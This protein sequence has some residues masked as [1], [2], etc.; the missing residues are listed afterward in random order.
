MGFNYD[1]EICVELA[2]Y[3]L[4]NGYVRYTRTNL[5]MMMDMFLLWDPITLLFVVVWLWKKRGFILY[6]LDILLGCTIFYT[7]TVQ[8]W[9]IGIISQILTVWIFIVMICLVTLRRYSF[10]RCVWLCSWG[11]ICISGILCVFMFQRRWC[12]FSSGG[13]ILIL[14]IRKF[15]FVEGNGGVRNIIRWSISTRTMAARGISW[16]GFQ[17]MEGALRLIRSPVYN[18]NFCRTIRPAKLLMVLVYLIG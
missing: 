17:W 6:K 5:L 11:S 14:F 3:P 4:L 13:I 2:N 16:I 18:H 8:S 1:Y 7:R 9:L 10:T 15:I 12:R